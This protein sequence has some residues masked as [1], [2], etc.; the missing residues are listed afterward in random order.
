MISPSVSS[1]ACVDRERA[2][3]SRSQPRDHADV[4]GVGLGDL[5]QGLTGRTALQCFLALIVR[6]LGLAAE[7]HAL[8]HGALA[9]VTGAFADEV[10]LEFGDRCQQR[11]PKKLDA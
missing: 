6:E 5:G 3:E 2:M 10:A 4:D 8:G 1:R 7:L 9:A 11:T